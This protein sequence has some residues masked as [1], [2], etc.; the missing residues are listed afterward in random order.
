ML[1]N[2]DP[3]SIVDFNAWFATDS[4]SKSYPVEVIVLIVGSRQKHLT[5]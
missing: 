1:Y 5:D 2:P 3:V 4:T